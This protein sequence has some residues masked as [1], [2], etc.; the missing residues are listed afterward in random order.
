MAAQEEVDYP[1]GDVHP[2]DSIIP[3]IVGP[4]AEAK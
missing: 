2:D 3:L 4:G 1:S